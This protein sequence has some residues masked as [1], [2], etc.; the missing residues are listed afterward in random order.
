MPTL[1]EISVIIPTYNREQMVCRAVRS[2]LRQAT[3]TVEV[4]VIDDGSTDGTRVAVEALT[5]DRV[6]YLYQANAGRSA[7]RNRGIDAATGRFV[8]FLDS[9]DAL[10]PDALARL[11][12]ILKMDDTVDLVAGG[13]Y[14]IS[15]DLRQIETVHPSAST[16]LDLRAWALDCPFPIHAAMLRRDCIGD[17]RFDR[18]AEPSEDWG[19]WLELARRGTCMRM[20]ADAVALYVFHGTNSLMDYPADSQSAAYMLNRFFSLPDLP[21]EVQSLRNRALAR[22]HLARGLRYLDQGKD[23]VG[24][25]ELEQTARLNPGWPTSDWPELVALCTGVTSSSH[26]IRHDAVSLARK[27]SLAI[28]TAFLGPGVSGRRL[29]RRLEAAVAEQRFWRQYHQRQQS[30]AVRGLRSM[31]FLDPRQALQSR[32]WRAAAHL[33][34]GH[35]RLTAPD[36]EQQDRARQVAADSLAA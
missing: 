21:T 24:Q 14:V 16:P 6:R 10:L 15:D 8:V 4:L 28:G 9:D 19:F 2:V 17:A 7:A 31:L 18:D 27:A 11:S 26:G 12:G 23:A 33:L 22:V 13:W 32:V 1:P 3:M 36:L 34:L 20:I 5:D 30:A 25:L 29:A 35:R